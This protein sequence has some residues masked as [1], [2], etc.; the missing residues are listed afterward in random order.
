MVVVGG[1]RDR[2]VIGPIFYFPIFFQLP[3]FNLGLKGSGSKFPLFI[4][5]TRSLDQVGY[6]WPLG[7]YTVVPTI[8]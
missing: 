5:S 8:F 1:G 6:T 3:L 2:F 7:P 4:I